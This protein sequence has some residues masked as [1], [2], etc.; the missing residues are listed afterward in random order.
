MERLRYELTVT[1]AWT[2]RLGSLFWIV[3]STVLVITGYERIKPFFPLW[4]VIISILSFAV[5]GSFM[6]HVIHQMRTVRRIYAQIKSVDLYNLEPLMAFS[7]LTVRVAIRNGAAAICDFSV[8]ARRSQAD[9]AYPRVTLTLVAVVLFTW[10]LMGVHRLLLDEKSKQLGEVESR[11]KA[12]IT[13][14]YQRV[15][16]AALAGVGEGASYWQPENHA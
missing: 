8:V 1:P 13:L 5:G 2:A 4:E 10:P 7:G 6:Q 11:L 16:G 3:T 9:A 15:D 14:L 12:M